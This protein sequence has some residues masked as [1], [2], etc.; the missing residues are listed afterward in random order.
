MKW[1]WS[2]LTASTATVRT[3][4][5]KKTKKNKTILTHPLST[6]LFLNC[7]AQCLIQSLYQMINVTGWCI[8]YIRRGTSWALSNYVLLCFTDHDWCGRKP[9][10]GAKSRVL[11]PAVGSG[12][13]LSLLLLKGNRL[14]LRLLHRVFCAVDSTPSYKLIQPRSSGDSCIKIL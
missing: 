4:Q 3:A 12:G 5:F 14:A 11:L 7:F 2:Q 6:D 9:R 8:L 1:A 13:R 10:G